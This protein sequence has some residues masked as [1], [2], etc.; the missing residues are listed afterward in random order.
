MNNK[1]DKYDLGKYVDTKE[2]KK[3]RRALFV[4]VGFVLPTIGAALVA[5][6]VLYEV[7]LDGSAEVAQTFTSPLPYLCVGWLSLVG[8]YLVIRYPFLES[9]KD[10]FKK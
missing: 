2:R 7:W 8:M 1:D 4:L 5:L 9:L 3:A 10:L 6:A